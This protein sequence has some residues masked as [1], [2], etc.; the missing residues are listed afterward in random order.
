MTTSISESV[1]TALAYAHI[2]GCLPKGIHMS[3][4]SKAFDMIEGTFQYY[5]VKEEFLPL[6]EEHPFVVGH[7]WMLCNG[8]TL[9][10]Y[11]YHS[12]RTIEYI[13]DLDNGFITRTGKGCWV[14]TR[15]GHGGSATINFDVS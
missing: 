13:R 14:W 6:I 9:I 1:K 3:T 12:S 8:F 7:E 4:W 5:R 15:N 10:P 11:Q 2:C